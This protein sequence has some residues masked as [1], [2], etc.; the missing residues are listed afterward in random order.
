MYRSLGSRSH[1]AGAND[2]A[3]DTA[4]V[5]ERLRSAGVAVVEH[6]RP[7]QIAVALDDGVRAPCSTHFIRKERRVNAAV[8][9]VGASGPRQPSDFVAAQ[10]VDR[11]NAD[12]DDVAGLD[13]VFVELVQRFVDQHRVAVTRR[14]RRGQHVQPS[15][16][17][18]GGAER[19]VARIDQVNSHR[20]SP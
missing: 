20:Y 14:R 2:A 9:D 4:A 6:R 1:R 10:R 3:V 12:S 8:D 19:H 16:G 11:V 5:V 13:R 18:D 7:D 15:R 17:D